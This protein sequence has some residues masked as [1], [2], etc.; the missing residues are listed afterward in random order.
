[1]I[2]VLCTESF[3]SDCQQLKPISTKRKQQSPSPQNNN[4]HRLKTAITLAANPFWTQKDNNT[5]DDGYFAWDCTK[6]LRPEPVNGI[7]ILSPLIKGSPRQ[8]RYINTKAKHKYRFASLPLTKKTQY[9]KKE[10]LH[11]H[12][13]YNSRAKV[14]S[15][16]TQLYD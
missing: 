8:Y 6:P 16:C 5:L 7:P 1:M 15:T 3:N 14:V 10:L 9:H 4:H 12:G 13:Q 11:R 2:V